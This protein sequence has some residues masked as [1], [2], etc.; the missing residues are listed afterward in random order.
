M[1]HGPIISFTPHIPICQGKEHAVRI[2]NGPAN[3]SVIDKL[4]S[5]SVNNYSSL[6]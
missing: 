3:Q 2:L 1:R 6:R 4:F 5:N